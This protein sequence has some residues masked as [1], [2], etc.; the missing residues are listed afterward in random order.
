[1]TELARAANAGAGFELMGL[2][3]DGRHQTQVVQDAGPQVVE[4]RRTAWMVAS[5]QADIERAFSSKG[6]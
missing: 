5:M 1:M 3:L 2:P 6:V 4:M